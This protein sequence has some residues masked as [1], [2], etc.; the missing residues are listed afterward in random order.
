M[1]KSPGRGYRYYTG[2]TQFPFGFGLSYTKF[3][4]NLR[5]V[6]GEV[7]G[8]PVPVLFSG[9]VSGQR[10]PSTTAG[11]QVASPPLPALSGEANDVVGIAVDVFNRGD[12][13]GALVL[14]CYLVPGVGLP[15]ELLPQKVLLS[16]NK[17]FLTVDPSHGS[18]T[19]GFGVPVEYFSTTDSEGDAWVVPGVHTL[20]ITNG[21]DVVVERQYKLDTPDGNPVKVFPFDMTPEPSPDKP[22]PQ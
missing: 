7:P 8:E 20:R 2:E 19:L 5:P 11:P 22:D 9:E 13:D 17:F 12:H 4:V 10:R 3:E 14:Q 15:G 16:F 1:T 18:A 21:N 6:L